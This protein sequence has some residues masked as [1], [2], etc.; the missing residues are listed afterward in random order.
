MLGLGVVWMGWGAVVKVRLVV[1]VR[2]RVVVVVVDFTP[3][4]AWRWVVSG[5]G[6]G[7]GLGPRPVIPSREII[8]VKE[9][10]GGERERILDRDDLINDDDDVVVVV[11]GPRFPPPIFPPR[12]T[13]YELVEYL[14]VDVVW[15]DRVRGGDCD[16]RRNWR[17]I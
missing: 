16:L 9:R 3:V 6:L 11:A 1:V 4:V 15:I 14:A 2:G 13:W 17:K 10:D 8:L 5:N 7:V 12:P